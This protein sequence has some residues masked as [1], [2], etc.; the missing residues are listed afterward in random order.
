MVFAQNQNIIGIPHMDTDFQIGSFQI[1]PYMP[2]AVKLRHIE[3]IP[4][5][6]LVPEP[7]IKPM[8]IDITDERTEYR[9]LRRTFGVLYLTG[10]FKVPLFDEAIDVVENYLVLY[11]YVP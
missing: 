7:D 1:T 3:V 4:A 2:F 6:P 9:T 5:V 8:E 11:S 10:L